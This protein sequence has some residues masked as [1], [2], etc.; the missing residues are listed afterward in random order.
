MRT[1][2]ANP[3]FKNEEMHIKL[4]DYINQK[5]PVLNPNPNINQFEEDQLPVPESTSKS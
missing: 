2:Y 1:K 3:Y 5:K 4:L